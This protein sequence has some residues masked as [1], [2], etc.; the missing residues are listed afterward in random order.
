MCACVAIKPT[1]PIHIYLILVCYT[2]LQTLINAVWFLFY[3]SLKNK[4]TNKNRNNSLPHTY[5]MSNCIWTCAFQVVS[6]S[7]CSKKMS[8]HCEAAGQCG[9]EFRMRKCCSPFFRQNLP[10]MQNEDQHDFLFKFLTAK[11]LWVTGRRAIN[12]GVLKSI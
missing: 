12:V 9:V 2:F 3:L 4:Q 1:L 10:C 11:Q 7:D 8:F 5:E 6:Q